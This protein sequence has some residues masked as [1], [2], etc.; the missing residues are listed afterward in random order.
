MSVGV[1]EEGGRIGGNACAPFSR[2]AGRDASPRARQRSVCDKENDCY[3]E[4]QLQ[5]VCERKRYR[6]WRKKRRKKRKDKDLKSKRDI[7]IVE[8]RRETDKDKRSASCLRWRKKNRVK[9][10]KKREREREGERA[11]VTR[12]DG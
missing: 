4:R 11:R 3:R 2:Y 7:A 1:E 5:S 10:V 6:D 12:S 8:A 9:G